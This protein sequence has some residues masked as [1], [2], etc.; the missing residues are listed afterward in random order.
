MTEYALI[1]GIL[2]ILAVA[3]RFAY[4]AGYTKGQIDEINRDRKRFDGKK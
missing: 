1:V 2:F 4:W 3:L